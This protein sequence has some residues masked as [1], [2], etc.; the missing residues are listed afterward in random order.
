[1]LRARFGMP[2]RVLAELFGVVIGTISTTERRVK[3]LLEQRKHTI[4]PAETTLKTP[5]ELIAYA[6]AH[7]ITLTP[8]AKPAR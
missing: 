2:Q 4:T 6:A 7:G 5:A 1:V 8:G 3:P